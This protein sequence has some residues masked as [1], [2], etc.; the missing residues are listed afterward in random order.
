MAVRGGGARLVIGAAGA[1]AE[2]P[3]L[4]LLPSD[5]RTDFAKT[6]AIQRRDPKVLF[7]LC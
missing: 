3:R 5:V 7:P 1:R 6:P 2:G 4:S